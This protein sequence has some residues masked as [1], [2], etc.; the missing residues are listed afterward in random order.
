MRSIIII[1]FIVSIFLLN[2]IC[3]TFIPRNLNKSELVD[4]LLRKTGNKIS[5]EK[6]LLLI[7]TGSRMM[8]EIKMLALSFNTS[9]QLTIPEARDLLIYSVDTLVSSIN[10][11]EK[12]RPYLVKY[13]FSS[14]N[15]QIRIFI[16]DD[17]DSYL[18]SE[19]LCTASTIEGEFNY[20]TWGS[21]GRLKEVL[22]ETYSDAVTISLNQAV[23]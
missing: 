10:D 3:Y 17:N 23:N 8:N 12:L 16:G 18:S 21:K 9:E 22:E 20:L 1:S 7:G 14:K 19:P 6:K 4:Q 15:V 13:P 5:N 11:D 2:F